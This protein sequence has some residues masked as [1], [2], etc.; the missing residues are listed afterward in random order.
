MGAKTS[1]GAICL[2]IVSNMI[3]QSL[4][5]LFY[6][7]SVAL[8]GTNLM[9]SFFGVLVGI[10]AVFVGGYFLAMSGRISVSK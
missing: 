6:G 7:F 9:W 8:Q 2:G 10:A 5:D 4:H 1:A 3:E